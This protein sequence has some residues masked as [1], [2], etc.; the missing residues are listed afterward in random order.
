MSRIKVLDVTLRDGG[1][2]NDFNFGQTYMEKILK[3]LENSGVNIIELGYIDKN[4]GSE[5]DRTQYC[6]EKVIYRNFL[7][8]KKPGVTYLAMMDYGKYNVDELTPRSD[9]GIDG[10]RV[11][12]HKKDWQNVISVG[13]KIIEKGYKFYVQPMI[14]MRYSDRE[15]LE[16]IESV[17]ENLSDASGF[18]IV[19]SFGEMRGNDVA[20][21]MHL[22]DNNLA[23]GMTVGFHSHNNLQLSYSNAM[24][25]LSF[26]TDRNIILDASVMGMGKGAGNLNTEL[27]LEHLNLYCNA[28]YNIAPL[29]ELIDAVIS[30]LHKE[31]YWGY[32]VEYY[33]SS[34]NH[35]TPSYASYF[36]NKHMLPIDSVSELLSM[37]DD[38]KKISFDEQ[39]A[40]ELYLKYNSVK[41]YDDSQIIKQ[42]R[43]IFK[44]KKALLIAPGKSIVENRKKISTII[45]CEDVIS[46]GLNNLLYDTDYILITRKEMLN[47]SIKLG[48]K[49]IVPSNIAPKGENFNMNIIDYE[50]WIISGKKTYDSSG[51]M[52][53]KLMQELNPK[54]I[55][56]AGFDGFTS[57]INDNYFDR[58]MRRPV[59]DEQAKQRNFFYKKLI[60]EIG[61]NQKIIFATNSAYES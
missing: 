39:Y 26:P 40:E 52:I 14:T 36:Y 54:E 37:I 4:K 30:V 53:L 2:V 33:L 12:F 48:R 35:C 20:R 61:K 34:V 32:S 44:N 21:L 16:L 41:I 27:L 15:L 19:D 13:R 46:V 22:V 1:C 58:T 31:M 47:Y 49:M 28:H 5:K 6:N 45:S 8:T 43:T 57:N 38:E 24:S 18:Y 55:I 7:K 23:P 50:R 29:M 42:L 10:I 17:N 9:K 60:S 11:A 3:A 25:L 51:V 59:T 56:L